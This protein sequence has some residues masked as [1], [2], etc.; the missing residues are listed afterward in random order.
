MT[1]V[2]RCTPHAGL[3]KGRFGPDRYDRRWDHATR[4]PVGCQTNQTTSRRLRR[5]GVLSGGTVAGI[6]GST[7]GDVLVVLI[8]LLIE[9]HG[10][11]VNLDQRKSFKTGE[12][13]AAGHPLSPRAQGWR[14]CFG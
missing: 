14:D 9:R 8:G 7:E 2:L 3:R 5:A 4:R 12:S 13:I 10:L 11:L 6:W 1:I